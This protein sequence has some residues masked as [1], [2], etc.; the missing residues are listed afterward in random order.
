M[1]LAKY[2]YDDQEIAYVVTYWLLA[3][4]LEIIAYVA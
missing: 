1:I 3:E 2:E 4:P